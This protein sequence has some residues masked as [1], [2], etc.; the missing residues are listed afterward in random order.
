MTPL[1]ST[2]STLAKFSDKFRT[3]GKRFSHDVGSPR[4]PRGIEDELDSLFG[5]EEPCLALGEPVENPELERIAEE[6]EEVLLW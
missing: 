3:S 1:S 5:D 2:S 4:S 6:M